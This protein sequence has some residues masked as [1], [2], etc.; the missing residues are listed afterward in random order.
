MG[1][2][3]IV[4][5]ILAGELHADPVEIEDE[6]KVYQEY[7]GGMIECVTLDSRWLMVV[8]D[9]GLNENL[10]LNE[11]ATL[12]YNNILNCDYTP[13]VGNAIIAGRSGPGFVSVP[14]D[15]MLMINRIAYY[16]KQLNDLIEQHSDEGAEIQ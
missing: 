16:Q 13:I 9:N 5:K 4:L 7:V 15:V 10:P 3:I 1:K 12:L 6:M 11:L 2:K 8:N 14:V